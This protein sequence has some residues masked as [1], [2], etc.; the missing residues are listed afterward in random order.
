MSITIN[1]F[2]DLTKKEPLKW[3]NYCE[4]IILKNGKIELEVSQENN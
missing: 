2:I 1:E 3:I 4:I